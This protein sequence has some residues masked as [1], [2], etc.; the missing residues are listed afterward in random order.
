MHIRLS[1]RWKITLLY[2]IL[3]GTVLLGSCLIIVFSIRQLLLQDMQLSLQ[4]LHTATARALA[5][6]PATLLDPFARP[7]VIMQWTQSNGAARVT[8]NLGRGTLA[9]QA[10]TTPWVAAVDLPSAR[11]TPTLASGAARTPFLV[12]SN[13]VYDSGGQLLGVLQVGQTL[14]SIDRIDHQLRYIV[15]P[16]LFGALAITLAIGFALAGRLL[17]P[18]A[19]ITAA[20]NQISSGNDL[21]QR[22]GAAA[23]PSDEVGRL[24]A[25]F[26]AMLDR[27]EQAF[28][29]QQQFT[30][31]ASHE[32]KTPLTAI[33][34]HAHLLRRRGQ[35][36][37]ELID[38]TA[39][40]IID[41]AERMHRLAQRLLD[42][43]RSGNLDA[44][45]RKPVAFAQIARRLV[46]ELQP[47]A[48]Q[49]AIE[50][51][52]AADQHAFTVYGSHDQLTQ[53]LLNLI[54]NALKFT[55][56]GG[57]VCVELVNE[58]AGIVCRVADSGGGIDRAD[59]PFIFDRFY[60]ADRSRQHLHAGFGLGL[61]ITREIIW[62]HGGSIAVE[63]QPGYG[64]SFTIRLPAHTSA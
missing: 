18:I 43:A 24:A 61:A 11:L 23:V 49:R 62:Q 52:C 38:E 6:N 58:G 33:L 14:A 15:A 63:S 5:S 7:D 1:I 27:L 31:D 17:Q 45:A 55:P 32:L 9:R 39:N 20:A 42:L 13:G 60:Q 35:T 54:D 37:P 53:A 44:H 34:G 48:Q 30:I 41:Q 22:L 19:S 40:A 47:I 25:T 3:L 50:L 46:A 8:V 2:G 57:R 64:T 16:C 10:A 59:L 36:H 4:T 12:F 51:Q 28:H 21:S 29:R 56:T 26:D